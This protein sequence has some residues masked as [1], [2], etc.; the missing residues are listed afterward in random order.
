M[1]H[2]L[3]ALDED[4]AVCPVVGRVK[5]YQAHEDLAQSIAGHTELKW[6]CK[7]FGITSDAIKAALDEALA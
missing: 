5:R 3:A 7:A 1:T 6:I 2:Y 4:I